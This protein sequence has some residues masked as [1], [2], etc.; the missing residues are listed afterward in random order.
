MSFFCSSSPSGTPHSFR[1]RVLLV[2]SRLW[3]FLFLLVFLDFHDL[4]T[5]KQSGQVL[6]FF[7]FCKAS[8][9][10][11]L[12]SVFSWWNWD[13]RVWEDYYRENM[14]FSLR[15]AER[16]PSIVLLLAMLTLMRSLRGFFTVKLLNGTFHCLL[17]RAEP[18]LKG[19]R[20]QFLEGEA[21]EF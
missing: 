5:F 2:L 8:L 1:H 15:R 14:P 18:A 16:M 10:L 17:L 19:R 20:I 9:N 12:T 7:F 4:D 11:G 21:F 13:S 3:Q 6:G